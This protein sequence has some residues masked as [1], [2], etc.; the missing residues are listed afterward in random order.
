MSDRTRGALWTGLTLVLVAI[1][2]VGV[3]TAPPSDDRV[4]QLG[5]RIRC[6]VCQGES[7]ADSPSE[8]ARAMM[9]RVEEQ[10]AAGASD[11]AVID[12][13]QSRYGDDILLDPPFS[14]STLVLWML[15]LVA[16]GMGVAL[17]TSTVR[18]TARSRSSAYSEVSYES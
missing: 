9:A 7:I 1:I 18:R 6:P 3:T 15:P 14:G 4:E 12:F 8:T 11:Q 10:V 2:V 17:V 13:F 16:L 5:Q